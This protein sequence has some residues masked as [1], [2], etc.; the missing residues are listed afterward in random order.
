MEKPEIYVTGH[1]NPD[2]DSIASAIGYAELKR[3]LDRDNRYT[4]AR[5]G[6]VNAQTDWALR[7][8]GADMPVFLPHIRLRARDVMEEE[9]TSATQDT[10]IREVGLTM[11]H[12]NVDLVPIVDP[13]GVLVGLVTEK[14]LARRY[15][16]E[17]QGA[18]DFSERPVEVAAIA[19]TL[20]GE[21]LQDGK[22]AVDGRLWVV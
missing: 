16:R 14:D 15:I 18:S 11:A 13:D 7:R 21:A 12:E 1:R 10:P 19:E 5:L 22:K 6:D 20:Q 4:P 9:F 8:S 2:L 17:S 3:R